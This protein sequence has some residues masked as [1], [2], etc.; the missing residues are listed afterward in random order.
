MKT[1]RLMG[2]ICGDVAGSTFQFDPMHEMDFTLFTN[3]CEFTDDT[4]MTLAVAK[5]FIDV[6]NPNN[7]SEFKRVLIQN[8]HELGDM[9]PEVGYGYRFLQ[10]LD[11]GSDQPYGSCGNGSAMRVSAVGWY[12][13]SLEEAELLAEASAEVTHDHPDGVAGAVAVAGAIYLAKIGESKDAIRDYVS[14]YYDVDF[15]LDA[16]RPGFKFIARCDGTVQPAVVAFLES[17]SYEDAI[18]RAISLGGDSDTLGAI[19]GSI[20]EAYYGIPDDLVEE[21][22]SYL[23]DYL[24][25]IAEEFAHYLEE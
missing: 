18:R 23:D 7:L 9:Y 25:D 2:A 16:I 22:M 8:M 4:V 3:T 12:A 15:S 11:S 21:A 14:R 5:T 20:A 10:W 1:S 24:L 13:H 17:N 6:S 19:A